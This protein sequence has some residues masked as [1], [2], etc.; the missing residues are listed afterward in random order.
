MSAERPSA[1]ISELLERGG[2]LSLRE[3][4]DSLRMDP[5]ALEPLMDLLLRRGKV[6]MVASGCPKGS[7][8]G[9]TCADRAGMLLYRLPD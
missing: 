8:A 3:L 7:C 6:E 1:R 9:C 5:E 4:A 2:V